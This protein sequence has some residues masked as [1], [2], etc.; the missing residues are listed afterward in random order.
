MT[1]DEA[2]AFALNLPGTE[3]ST[4]YGKPAVKHVSNGRAFLF[5]SHEAA[6]SFA[7]SLGLDEIELLMAT[8]PATYWQSPHYRGYAAVLVRYA[9]EDEDRVRDVI[10]RSHEWN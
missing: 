9:A 1:F 6:T 5:T 10:R 2:V 8:E 7:V 4:S 3:L